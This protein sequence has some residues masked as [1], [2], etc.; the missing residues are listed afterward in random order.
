MTGSAIHI[1]LSL[2]LKIKLYPNK[3]TGDLVKK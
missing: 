1:F 3:D 2:L